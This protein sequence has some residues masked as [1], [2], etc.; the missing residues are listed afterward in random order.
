MNYLNV[1]VDTLLHRVT[2]LIKNI[3]EINFITSSFLM[4]IINEEKIVEKQSHL[5][6]SMWVRVGQHFIYIYIIGK[7]AIHLNAHP[8]IIASCNGRANELIILICFITYIS[9]KIN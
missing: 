8:Y 4:V 9:E 7:I 3:S 5:E 2:Q 1:L 6:L